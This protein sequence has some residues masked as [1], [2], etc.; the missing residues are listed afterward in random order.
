MTLKLKTNLK[1]PVKLT[2]YSLTRKKNKT[3]IILVT[4]LL[5]TEVEDLVGGLVVLVVQTFQIFLK[6]SLETLVVVEDLEAG[7]LIT[8]AQT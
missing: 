3:M 4:Q 1:K 2:E 5:K 8:E 7:E 6:T